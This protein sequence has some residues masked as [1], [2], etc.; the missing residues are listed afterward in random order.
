MREEGLSAL[1]D[2]LS[3]GHCVAITVLQVKGSAPREVGAMML[4][5]ANGEVGSIGGGRLE[6]AAQQ[7]AQKL[8][9]HWEGP[10]QFS[11][12]QGLG[13]DLEQ[14]C[15]GAVQLLFQCFDHHHD[16]DLQ[17]AVDAKE[18]LVFRCTGE[19]LDW[20]SAAADLEGPPE[21]LA[22]VAATRTDGMSRFV[23]VG[24]SLVVAAVQWRLELCLYGA[25]HVATALVP[26]LAELPFA[27]Y[28][29]DPLPGRMPEDLPPHVTGTSHNDPQ[30]AV[31]L[32]SEDAVHLVMTHSHA[33]DEDIC[34]AV[35]ERGRFGWLG[36][37]GSKSKRAR[38]VHRLA[39]RGIDA[40]LL[41]R[42]VCPVGLPG[43]TGKRP[44]TIALAIAAQLAA[45]LP[46]GMR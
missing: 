6:F 35:L 7:A 8:L 14:C 19:A 17:Q 41:Q 20:R 32:A 12:W 18:P 4:V 10:R 3:R 39:R 34:H 11:E 30:S 25:G 27:I 31:S 13:P 21:L 15:G 33:L 26:L 40:G 44:A 16:R 42:L 2:A 24:E 28:W 1:L 9:L 36:L 43:V 45:G 29:F 23:S 22:A 38:F 37:I 5:S 46:P